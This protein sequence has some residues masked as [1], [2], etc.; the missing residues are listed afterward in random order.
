MEREAMRPVTLK[1]RFWE[2][3]SAAT[4]TTNT[5]RVLP[6]RGRSWR[7]N[8]SCSG[9][10]LRCRRLC[11]GE[12]CAGSLR[13]VI[14]A[15][16]RLLEVEVHELGEQAQAVEHLPIELVGGDDEVAQEH[17][18]DLALVGA[19]CDEVVELDVASLADA[20]DAAH[21]LLESHE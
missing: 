15:G 13:G 1:P 9:E 6:M 3:T 8:S 21:P 4:T 18:E 11:G 19:R 17:L 12:R 14:R 2:V 20:V 7:L 5:F 16:E 10:A